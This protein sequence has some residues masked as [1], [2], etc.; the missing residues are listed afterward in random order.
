MIYYLYIGIPTISEVEEGKVQ[1]MAVTGESNEGNVQIEEIDEP[2]VATPPNPFFG[3]TPT[4]F[5]QAGMYMSIFMYILYTYVNVTT[6]L[7]TYMYK[8]TYIHS[9][10]IL[11]KCIHIT[12]I[13]CT[14]SGSSLSSSAPRAINNPFLAQGA[15]KGSLLFGSSAGGT[16]SFASKATSF[17]GK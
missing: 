17:S 10:I 7:F 16:S 15:A 11:Y 8:C 2:T 4:S 14:N 1:D 6:Y 13:S 3:A 9:Y 5:T 12:P